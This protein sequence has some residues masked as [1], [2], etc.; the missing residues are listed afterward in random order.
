MRVNSDQACEE[1]QARWRILN[2]FLESGA[3]SSE[4]SLEI[5]V[6]IREL[7]LRL[8]P[9]QQDKRGFSTFRGSGH[10]NFGQMDLK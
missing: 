1:L 9:Q 5:S 4:I 7:V 10:L 3:A 8:R 6:V 2:S